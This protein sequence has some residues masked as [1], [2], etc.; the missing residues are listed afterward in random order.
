[1]KNRDCFYVELAPEARYEK[2]PE[3]LNTYGI[4]YVCAVESEYL[5]DFKPGHGFMG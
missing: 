5:S 2:L 4:F 1:M 3:G